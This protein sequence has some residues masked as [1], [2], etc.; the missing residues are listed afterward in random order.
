[1]DKRKTYRMIFCL[2]LFL[3]FQVTDVLAQG[4][5]ISLRCNNIPLPTALNRVE[6]QSGYFKIHYSYSDVSNYRVTADIKDKEAP[7]AVRQLLGGLP[8]QMNVKGKFIQV[9]KGE[10]VQLTHDANVAKGKLM[11]TNGEPLIGASVKVERHSYRRKRLL[12]AA[13]RKSHRRARIF[14][15]RYEDIQAQGGKQACEH[16]SRKRHQHH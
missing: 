16:H 5:K 4:K 7:E 13:R 6:Q 14:I 10:A 9:K 2:C 11:D 15:Y 3:F 12:R 1:M 8:F